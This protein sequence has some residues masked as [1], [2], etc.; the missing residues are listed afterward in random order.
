[1]R[2]IRKGA[3]SQ[4]VYLE[5]LDSS[6]TTGAR[7]TGLVFNTAS[8][9]A[10]YARNGAA[11]VAITLV[12]QT[13][14][15]AWTSGGF[16][17]VDGTNMPGVYRLDVPD[18]AFATGADSVVVTLKGAANMVQVSTEVQ[19]V[20]VDVQDSVRAGLTGLANAVPG[21][22]GGLFIAGANAATTVNLTGNV[23]GSVGS[24]TAGVTVTTNNDK[25][26]Y[27][28][29]TVSDKTGYSLSAAGVQAVWDA[30]TSALTT[31]GSIGKRIADNLDVVLS[32]RGA[33]TALTTLQADTDDIQ[34]RLPAALVSGRMDASVGAMAAN[35]MTAAAAAADLT[36]ELQAG[37]ATGSIPSAASV[38]SA[39]RTE[40]TTELGRLDAAVSSRLVS[41]SVTVGTNTDKTGY[42]L[43][44]TQPLTPASV[45]DTVGGALVGARAQAFGKWTLV[46][47]TLTMYAADNTTVVRTFTLD[48]ATAPTSR[49]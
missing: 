38:A 48:S 46:G 11:R 28:A 32:T 27:T 35:V 12:T 26:G 8:L 23:S 10:S 45:G 16:V 21:A 36:T 20:A 42:S 44:L 40:L 37:L 5:V 34:A 7:L 25:T 1:V 47:T 9:V 33:A 22:A 13:A 41:G 14:A 39:V 3:T 15:G 31:V 18:A 4:T 30:L 19:L 43:L 2:L 17:A 29:S 24:V 6:S 49:T